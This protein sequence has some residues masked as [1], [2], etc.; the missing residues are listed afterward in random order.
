VCSSD[1]D[2]RPALWHQT[3]GAEDA[4]AG[5]KNAEGFSWGRKKIISR[6]SGAVTKR[7]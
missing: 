5:L 3:N 4:T 7:Q 2:F 6:I 1:L